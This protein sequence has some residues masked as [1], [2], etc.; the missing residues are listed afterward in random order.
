MTASNGPSEELLELVKEQQAF[1]EMLAR[2][3]VS[4]YRASGGSIFCAKG[5]R[6]C[7]SLAVH[8]GFAEALAI[9]SYLDDTLR[10]AVSAYATKLKVLVAGVSALPEY[11]RLHRREMGSCPLLDAS[12]SCSVYPVRPLTCRSLISTKESC[13]CGTDFATVSASDRDGYLA[14]LDRKVVNYPSHYVA[15]LQESA[16][17]LE[18]VENRRMRELFGFS[19]YGNLGVLLELI[20]QHR[21]AEACLE[22][23]ATVE[24][25]I[26]AAGF[27]HPLLLTV[28]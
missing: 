5:C 23:R 6:N 1:L 28:G 2:S 26:A 14:T 7:C 15:V 24:A 8:T 11:L 21:L 16:Q 27:Q 12:G 19:L 18:D 13:W 4:D 9:A 22:E 17:E 10:Q 20:C 25:V 3:W